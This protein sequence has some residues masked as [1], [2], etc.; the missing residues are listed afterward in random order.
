MTREGG[1]AARGVGVACSHY[2]WSG[3]AT[4]LLVTCRLRG[5]LT[6]QMDGATAT[7]LMQRQG[8]ETG[9]AAGRAG[10]AGTGALRGGGQRARS[11]RPGSRQFFE[12]LQAPGR[13]GGRA[14]GHMMGFI[15]RATHRAAR[16]AA[17]FKPPGRRASGPAQGSL[18]S[19]A[20]PRLVLVSP[21]EMH[22][23]LSVGVSPWWLGLALEARRSTRWPS[24]ARFAG[25]RRS[26]A[27]VHL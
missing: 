8:L 10:G 12:E 27:R 21:P 5:T 20:R 3:R 16:V 4:A 13:A 7:Q 14:A 22:T 25:P 19:A 17:K 6:M 24:R 15:F 23:V 26:A 18:S 1:P 2:Y 11:C 9:A